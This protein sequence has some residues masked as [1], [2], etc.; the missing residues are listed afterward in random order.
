MSAYILFRGPGHEAK[1]SP[2]YY[3]NG[4][5]TFLNWVFYSPIWDANARA[6]SPLVELQNLGA[7]L[8]YIP[9]PH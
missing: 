2:L 6:A 4:Q 1:F 7:V 3:G 9:D 5:C 8:T